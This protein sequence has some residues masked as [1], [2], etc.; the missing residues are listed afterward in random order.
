MIARIEAAHTAHKH[1]IEE[2]YISHDSMVD[3]VDDETA[4]DLKRKH[5]RQ[6]S[7]IIAHLEREGWMDK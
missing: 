2:M 7:A 1:E 4:S 3:I 6:Q 5:H